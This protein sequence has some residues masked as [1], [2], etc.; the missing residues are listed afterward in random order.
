MESTRP[1]CS[2]G[3]VFRVVGSRSA[4][5]VVASLIAAC[6][7]PTSAPRSVAPI[8]V[9]AVDLEAALRR[10]AAIESDSARGVASIVPV[11]EVSFA[12]VFGGAS[13]RPAVEVT[14]GD[15]DPLETIADAARRRVDL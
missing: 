2:V 10:D 4:G 9:S 11:R 13:P 1:D 12:E 6:S 8:T 7:T 5:V 3:S 15:R 14:G